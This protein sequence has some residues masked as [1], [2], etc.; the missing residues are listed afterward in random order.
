MNILDGF[1][2][3]VL[4]WAL[5]KGWQSGFLKEA[6]SLVGFI[7][8]LVIAGSLYGWLSNYL[9]PALGS[10]P[11]MSNILSFIILWIA[12][13]VG[14]GILARILSR[15]FKDTFI[16][17]VN[18]MLGSGVSFIKYAI[19]LSCIVNVMAF[20]HMLDD[21]KQRD[22]SLLYTPTKAFVG[23]SF[24]AIMPADTTQTDNADAN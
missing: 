20:I 14:L 8:G 16:G 11:T 22:E 23:W 21:Q 17:G 4:A 1:I 6:A 2:I 18:N 19:M 3:V 5:W 24:R 13:P 7:V 12:V 9:T 15:T 10:S